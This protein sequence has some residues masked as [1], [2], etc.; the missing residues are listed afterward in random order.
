MSLI[1]L[2]VRAV[3]SVVLACFKAGAVWVRCDCK[4]MMSD[5]KSKDRRG[6]RNPV[7]PSQGT[8]TDGNSTTYC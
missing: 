6:E 3:V 1:S 4:S 8:D 5:F 7:P 2:V